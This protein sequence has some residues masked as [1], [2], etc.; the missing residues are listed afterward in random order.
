MEG[1]KKLW[2]KEKEDLYLKISIIKEW[3]KIKSYD[4][5]LKKYGTPKNSIEKRKLIT[6]ANY[7]AH[8]K[9]NDL[10]QRFHHANINEFKNLLGDI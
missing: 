9:I 10:Y 4:R 8:N 1:L 7:L 6:K 2:S 5:L 3:E